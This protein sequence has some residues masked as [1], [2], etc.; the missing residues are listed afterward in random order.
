MVRHGL[1]KLF[2][3]ETTRFSNLKLPHIKSCPK[4]QHFIKVQVMTN[5]QQI[6][7]QRCHFSRYARPRQRTL[8][9]QARSNSWLKA[10]RLTFLS[11]SKSYSVAAK[12]QK[13][14]QCRT[15]SRCH[16]TVKH[17]QLTGQLKI[18]LRLPNPSATT[19]INKLLLPLRTS[20]QKNSK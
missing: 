12:F 1:Q 18:F 16:R 11:E 17:L 6:R 10:R 8:C 5:L 9:R 14:P 4:C 2:K 19:K 3:Y 13:L 7:S 15:T 20:K